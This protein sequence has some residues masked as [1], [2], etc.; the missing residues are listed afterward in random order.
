MLKA[1]DTA[2]V[3]FDLAALDARARRSFPSAWIPT[4]CEERLEDTPVSLGR[5]R[6][7]IL[8]RSWARRRDRREG[9]H[10]RLR[11]SFLGTPEEGLYL[12]LDSTIASSLAGAVKF[13]D[14]Y[15]YDCLEQVTSK[16]FARVLFPHAC[17][18]GDACGPRSR[19]QVRQ[20]GRRLQLL[21]RLC[22]AQIQLLR[23]V[24]CAHLL[25]AAK[26]ERYEA[27][28]RHRHRCAFRIPRRRWPRRRTHTSR[29]TRSTSCPPTGRKDGDKA[30]T[31]AQ[32]GDEIGV[33]GYGFLGLSYHAMGDT[34]VRPGRPHAAEELRARRHAHRHAGRHGE[35]LA[36]VRR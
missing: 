25:A 6:E 33:F 16:L 9:G 19:S 20:L 26:S 28:G 32:M 2:E 34:Q 29:R 18:R 3:A 17:R 10:H 23:I 8:H 7:R 24:A 31:L 36:V 12:S 11:Q 21:G 13:L 30:D 4:S 14:V 1:G 35:R 22:P 27:A 5:A 15:P